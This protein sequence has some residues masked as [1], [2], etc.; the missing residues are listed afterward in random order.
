MKILKKGNPLKERREISAKAECKNCDCVI[1]Y[2]NDDISKYYQG[3]TGSITCPNCHKSIPTSI[4][5]PQWHQVS[6]E[7]YPDEKYKELMEALGFKL[8]QWNTYKPV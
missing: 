3:G 6:D 7:A 4:S 8:D 5:L 1:E 2:K